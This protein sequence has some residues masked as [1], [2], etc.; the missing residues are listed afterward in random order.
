MPIQCEIYPIGSRPNG[1]SVTGFLAVD[2]KLKKSFLLLFRERLSQ[3][4]KV[5]IPLPF[6]SAAK[7][8]RISGEGKIRVIENGVISVEM[9]Q[10]QYL[11]A[12]SL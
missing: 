1:S 12:E 6:C 9:P 5:T 7:W 8:R 11:F 3:E 2:K 4:E 10:K